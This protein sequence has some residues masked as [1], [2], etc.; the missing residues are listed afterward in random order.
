MQPVYGSPR[1]QFFPTST[2]P[3]ATTNVSPNSKPIAARHGVPVGQTL[4][5][6][7]Y[8]QPTQYQTTVPAYPT[9]TQYG[10]QTTLYGSQPTTTT[11]Y[12][13]TQYPPVTTAY[14]P[15]TVTPA[16]TATYGSAV[17]TAAYPAVTTGYQATATTT[18]YP[19][20][21]TGY[22]TTGY[23]TAAV[24]SPG[25]YAAGAAITK[26]GSGVVSGQAVVTGQ[27][28]TTGHALQT[29]G[30]TV[31]ERI[32]HEGYGP[33][34]VEHRGFHRSESVTLT[35]EELKRLQW[36]E[37]HYELNPG[38]K[39]VHEKIVHE[40]VVEVPKYFV[41]EKI[42]EIP[43]YE[44]IDK[45]VEVPE[46]VQEEKVVHVPK[47][48]YQERIVTVP[49]KVIKENIVEVPEIEYREIPIEKIVEVPEVREEIVTREVAVPQYVDV[50][51]P[52]Y[53]CVG[54]PQEIE[55]QIPVGVEVIS[56]YEYKMP[57]LKPRYTEIAVPIYVPRFIEVPVPAQMMDPASINE[58]D[59]L[60]QQIAAM[61]QKQTIN[62]A[63]F[64]KL[65][66]H[67]Q[68]NV[69]GSIP[70]NAQAQRLQNP[71]QPP[72]QGYRPNSQ[73]PIVA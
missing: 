14:K 25:S 4:P 21:T 34:I 68:S 50:P 59:K 56:T 57:K 32:V 41:E 31:H 42:V 3:V 44:Y 33:E 72:N 73:R 55:R 48:E 6:A 67:Q 1:Q 43:E 26:Y 71:N 22:Q 23:Q 66:C 11:A 20:V 17:T 16:V 30:S 46:K 7:A 19:A 65:I 8:Q 9:T 69:F 58:A 53:R 36:Y 29:L 28:V 70:A 62:L 49:K 18:A 12:Q 52:E 60:A 5:V 38:E 35:E 37:G 61:S 10:P 63:D 40:K 51:V 64:Q 2:T 15:T 54:I 39:I 27:K 47:I 24:A 45:I 13:T